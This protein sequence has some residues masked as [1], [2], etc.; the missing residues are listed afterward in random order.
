MLDRLSQHSEK[1]NA[2]ARRLALE[3]L[4]WRQAQDA[5]R[6]DTKIHVYLESAGVLILGLACHA[7]N[8]DVRSTAISLARR[9]TSSR[10]DST[11]NRAMAHRS[12]NAAI[13]ANGRRST[14]A[15]FL[16]PFGDLR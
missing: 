6:E 3:P 8:S 1:A 9:V 7:T 16:L 11:I 10:Q 12:N 4:A 2:A 14:P 13:M 15:S 5:I